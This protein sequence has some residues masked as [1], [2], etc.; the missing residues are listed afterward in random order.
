MLH[1]LFLDVI[2]TAKDM[3]FVVSVLSNGYYLNKNLVYELSSYVDWIGFSV[4][5]ANEAV[6][7]SLGRGKGNHVKH[8]IENS[9]ISCTKRELS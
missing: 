4:D 5:S 3:D 7:V 8:I 2:K 9:Q 6:E 1:P